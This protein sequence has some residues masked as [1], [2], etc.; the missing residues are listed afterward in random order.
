MIQERG[1]FLDRERKPS[2]EFLSDGGI[3]LS[4]KTVE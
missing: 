1:L 3:K 4:R 2:T